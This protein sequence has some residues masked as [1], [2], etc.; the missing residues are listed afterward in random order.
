MIIIY[1]VCMT[2]ICHN[3][4]MN[5]MYVHRLP[6]EEAKS[7]SRMESVAELMFFKDRSRMFTHRIL[8]HDQEATRR[9]VQAEQQRT[10]A[11]KKEEQ[12]AAGRHGGGLLGL[13]GLRKLGSAAVSGVQQNEQQGEEEGQEEKF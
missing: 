5:N 2:Y 13:G 1:D 7:R 8:F 3:Y 4:I 12:A 9:Q 10:V 11:A 6:L